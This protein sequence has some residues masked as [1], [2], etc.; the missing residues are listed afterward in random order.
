MSDDGKR[1][2]LIVTRVQNTALCGS[3]GE[4]LRNNKRT[5]E[6]FHGRY[7]HKKSRPI[8]FH[9]HECPACGTLHYLRGVYPSFRADITEQEPYFPAEEEED[10]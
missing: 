2:A 8:T 9:V 4:E 10:V 5:A 7:H 1:P 6:G 3:C